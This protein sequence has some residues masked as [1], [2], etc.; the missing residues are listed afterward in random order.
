VLQKKLQN[1]SKIVSSLP[2]E[3]ILFVI[4][5]LFF[6]LSRAISHY[7]LQT[8]IF[9]Q[10]YFD[11][12]LWNTVC[13]RPMY[14]TV[15][16]TDGQC[17]FGGH[18]MPIL[19]LFALPYFIYP[20][21]LWMF[22][23]QSLFVAGTATLIY[24]FAKKHLGK[25]EVKL[26]LF[27]LLTNVSFRYL[28]LH[29]F[30]LDVV[31]TFLTALAL[32]VLLT[33]NKILIPSLIMLSG[34]LAKEIA[35]IVIASFGMFVFIFRKK[36]LAGLLLFFA[37]LIGTAFIAKEI[38]PM[39]T[40]SGTY[41]YSNYYSHFG[42]NIYEQMLNIVRHPLH[43]LSF[44]FTPPNILYV[45]LLLGPLAFLPIFYP[46]LLTIGA[47]PLFQNLLS[48]YRFQKDITV[49]YSY[50]FIPILFISLILA[51]KSLKERGTW[52]KIWRRSRPCIIFFA[53][54]SLLAFLILDV[55]I[56]V[57]RQRVFSAHKLMHQ[58]PEQAAASAS[59][60]L[61]VHLQYREKLYL[62]PDVK[63]ADYV[64]YE[65]VNWWLFK[66]KGDDLTKIKEIWKH[67]K[68]KTL[69]AFIFLG[70][71]FPNPKDAQDIIK[72]KGN[73]NFEL[74]SHENGVYLYQRNK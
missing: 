22:G 37:G 63:N 8:C 18:F 44:V 73:K 70:K 69:L 34:F 29:D 28:G 17:I 58:I 53:I 3:L 51:I 47:L 15:P 45:I 10:Y 60:S 21:A 26:V 27:L 59:S 39:F 72:F 62:F 66:L 74:M 49:Q 55:R 71:T 38:V 12:P 52:D 9:D 41:P 36:R 42:S 54:L 19:F 35:G 48:S 5:F 65:D 4:I 14:L 24:S 6:F 64:I 57:P 68:Y 1:I 7:N 2:G 16:D 23:I 13:G 61:L 30:Q 43:T 11:N 32:Y 56:Y 25:Q 20:S 67:K 31:I 50:I 40:I 46:K 33:T